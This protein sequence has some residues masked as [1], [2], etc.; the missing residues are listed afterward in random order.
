MTHS[1]LSAREHS[2]REPRGPRPFVH[3]P[4]VPPAS[5]AAVLSLTALTACGGGQEGGEEQDQPAGA[6]AVDTATADTAA[7]GTVEPSTPPL[8]AQ[9]LEATVTGAGFTP[10]AG[11][12]EALTTEG[13]QEL[14]DAVG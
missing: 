13:T 8:D 10:D 4:G 2:A 9:A 6:S 11:D 12:G 3:R 7:D 5:L 14:V 1:H